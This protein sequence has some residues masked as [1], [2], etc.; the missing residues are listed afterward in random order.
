[1][2]A[3]VLLGK[4]DC[5]NGGGL[6]TSNDAYWLNDGYGHVL[7]RDSKAVRRDTAFTRTR[8]FGGECPG[9]YYPQLLRDGWRLLEGEHE[10]RRDQCDVFEKELSKTWILRKIAHAGSPPVGRSIYWDEHE[11]VHRRTNEVDAHPDW[12]WADL[13][14]RRV[15]WAAGGKLLS[16]QLKENGVTDE[17]EL[18]DFNG[19]KFERLL[20]PYSWPPV[21]EDSAEWWAELG[22]PHQRRLSRHSR[23]ST[24][25]SFGRC[26]SLAHRAQSP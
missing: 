7:L 18:H 23:C 3:E 20:A 4:G 8:G 25:R 6:F 17:A 15:V 2:K 11:L 5:W 16:G 10:E 12:E 22:P 13:D 1:L 21:A 14:G 26:F 19:M 24:D 9:V